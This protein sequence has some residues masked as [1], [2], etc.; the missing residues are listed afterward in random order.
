[1]WPLKTLRHADCLSGC[2]WI[3]LSLSV[4]VHA[5][6]ILPIGGTHGGVDNPWY[7]SP[8]VAPILIGSLITGGGFLVLRRGLCGQGTAGLG[9]FLRTSAR[10][11]WEPPARQG[12]IAVLVLLGYFLLVRFH[13]LPGHCG[14][15]YL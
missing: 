1:M 13:W 3:L 2:A 6:W 7:A 14:E 12:L 8:A 11:L 5:W 9:P 15:N 10:A 4:I